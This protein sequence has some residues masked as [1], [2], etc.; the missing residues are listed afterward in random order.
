[1][2]RR[3]ERGRCE[4]EQREVRTKAEKGEKKNK[5]KCEEEQREVRR[6]AESNEER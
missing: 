1:V 4:E 2:Q 3:A 6:R 5:E